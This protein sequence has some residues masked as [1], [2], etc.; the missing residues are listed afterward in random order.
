MRPFMLTFLACLLGLANGV[1]HAMEPD[2]LAAVSTAVAELKSARASVRFAA[3]WGVGHALMLVVVGGALM[4][5]RTRMPP[6][7]E[8]GFEIGVAVML[9][10]LGARAIRQASRVAHQHPHA[11]AGRFAVRPL[12]IGIVHG[13]AGSGAL[14]A[15][16][17]SKA[18]SIAAGLLFLGLYGAGATLGMA[19]LAG[20]A[21]VPLARIARQDRWAR[22]LLVAV[23]TLSLLMGIGWGVAAAMRMS[24]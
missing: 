13:L 1:R 21:G 6:R 18:P 14:T 7:V 17:V 3:S 22:R 12:A 9:I 10:V 5:L 4:L 20:A 23:G 11:V 2:H 15:L 19:A 16:V 8:E 24:A